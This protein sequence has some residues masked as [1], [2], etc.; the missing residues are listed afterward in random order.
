M[1]KGIDGK[2]LLVTSIGHVLVYIIKLNSTVYSNRLRKGEKK[3]S[4][5]HMEEDYRSCME[6][7]EIVKKPLV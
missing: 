7:E 2:Y 4:T 1:Y 6:L 3:N 5:I